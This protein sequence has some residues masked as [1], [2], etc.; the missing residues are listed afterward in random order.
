[1]TAKRK[2]KSSPESYTI[3]VTTEQAA[4]LSD[5]CEL[6][7]R[8]RIGQIWAAL[9]RLPMPEGQWSVPHDVRDAVES[10]L[11]PVVGFNMRNSSLGIRNER[12]G[13]SGKI[14]F[15]LHQ[16]IR[17]RLSWDQAVA[18]GTIKVGERRDFS[19]MMGVNFDEPMPYGDTAK[20]SKNENGA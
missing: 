20:I 12:V 19:K 13:P 1:M 2:P 11:S 9:D 8:I 3:T 7:S 14:A 16:M 18:D 17:H 10:L 5:A 6:L 15:Y 4:V